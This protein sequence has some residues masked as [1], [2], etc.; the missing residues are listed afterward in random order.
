MEDITRNIVLI[1]MPGA[2]KTT[3]A[4]ILQEKTGMPLY[5]IDEEIEKNMKMS[6]PEIF[7]TFGEQ[8]FRQFESAML[9]KFASEE[10]VII[11]AGGGSVTTV[12]NRPMMQKNARVYWI[13]R[14]LEELSTEGRPLSQ[15]GLERL[16]EIY[17]IREPLYKNFSDV[18]VEN[19]TPE[20]C[21]QEILDDFN[22]GGSVSRDSQGLQ[23]N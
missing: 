22:A 4:K 2:G 15:G 18:A 12:C 13:K 23:C 11:D 1:G 5:E 16:Q 7:K 17:K 8:G 14:P 21:A 3:V 10:G 6:I 9:S 19:T 20:A